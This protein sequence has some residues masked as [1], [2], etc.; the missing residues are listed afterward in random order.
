MH[1]VGESVA[2][3]CSTVQVFAAP[4][5]IGVQS[6]P[7]EPDSWS[8]AVW[9]SYLARSPT[10]TMHSARIAEMAMPDDDGPAYFVR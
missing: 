8:Y 9:R 6:R 1:S 5:I 4:Y 3:G 2:T 7:L 10:S